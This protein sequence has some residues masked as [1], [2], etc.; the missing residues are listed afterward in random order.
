MAA[1]GVEKNKALFGDAPL[2]HPTSG[3]ARVI[4]APLRLEHSHL[5]GLKAEVGAFIESGVSFFPFFIAAHETKRNDGRQPRFKWFYGFII[6]W[7][8]FLSHPACDISALKHPF[9]AHDT[10]QNKCR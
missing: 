4:K 6:T 3:S 9:R 5:A 8:R 7:G 2:V 1:T 10:P